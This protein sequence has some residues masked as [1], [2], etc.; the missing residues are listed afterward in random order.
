MGRRTAIVVTSTFHNHNPAHSMSEPDSSSTIRFRPSKKRKYRQRAPD[1]DDGGDTRPALPTPRASAADF[2]QDGQADEADTV[3]KARARARLRGVNFRATTQPESDEPS[4]AL[5]LRGE[6]PDVVPVAGIADRFTRQT[7]LT[8]AL[9]D[10]HL[11]SPRQ[12]QYKSQACLAP[13]TYCHR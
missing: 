3:V 4:Q 13:R 2:F 7:G 5:V 1:E 12:S 11:V 9:D 10:R 8:Q 6:D